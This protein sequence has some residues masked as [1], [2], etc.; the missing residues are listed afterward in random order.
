MELLEII[1]FCL[2]SRP[3][4]DESF[5]VRCARLGDNVEM[6]V[7]NLLMSDPAIVLLCVRYK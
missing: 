7:G 5:I 6:D 2:V 4:D 1:M 3:A